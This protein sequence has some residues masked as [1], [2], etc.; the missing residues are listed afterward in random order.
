MR[1]GCLGELRRD[2]VVAMELR[3][4]KKEGTEIKKHGRGG[5]M[6]CPILFRRYLI[7]LKS[8]GRIWEAH[9]ANAVIRFNTGF[10][11]IAEPLSRGDLSTE[12]SRFGMILCFLYEYTGRQIGADWS[13][14]SPVN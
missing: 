2:A 14:W 10:R 6:A 11:P 12:I 13:F 4:A 5:S 8:L 1:S 9:P 7:L 3:Q